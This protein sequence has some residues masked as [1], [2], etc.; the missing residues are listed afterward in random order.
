MTKEVSQKGVLEKV[1]HLKE[2]GTNVRTEVVAGMTTFFTMAYILFVNPMMLSLTGMNQEGVFVATVIASVVG[3]LIMAFV[4]NVPYA[5][6]P[7]MG[8]NAFFTFTVCFAMGFTWQQAL[9]LVLICGVVNT[10]ITLSGLRKAIIKAM[11]KLLQAAISGGIGM[12]IAYIGFKDLGLLK[13]TADAPL[14]GTVPPEGAISE[15]GT[16]VGAGVHT[17]PGLVTFVE[18]SLLLG[19]FGLVLIIVLLVKKVKGAILIGILATT[20]IGIILDLTGILGAGNTITKLHEASISPESFASSIGAI[21]DTAFKI[22]LLGLFDNPTKTLLA[23]TAAVGFCLTDIFDCIGT[24]IG[25]GRKSG[26]FDDEDWKKFEEGGNFKSRMDRALV[27]DLTATTIG[28]FVGTS[29]TTTYVESAS[30][31]A[32]GGRSGLT[33]VVVALFFAACIILAPVVGVVPQVAVAPALIVVG[34]MMM[35]SFVEIDWKKFELAVPAFLGA[36]MMP[37]TYSITN[38]IAFG[39]ISY[40]IVKA[41]TGKLK[42]VHPIAWLVTGLFI[43]NFILQALFT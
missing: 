12:F 22:D 36:V 19:L 42:E 20:L 34:A 31:I 16:V 25:T 13:F 10:I 23:I 6:A 4:A 11:P 26:I 8:L 40:C 3:T 24:F 30:G 39:F 33:S 41:V 1:F 37:L 43:A 35:S 14:L 7:G 17:T 32:E 29:N 18:P 2:L 28:A 27:A 9:G 15:L 38:G 5:L 21:S